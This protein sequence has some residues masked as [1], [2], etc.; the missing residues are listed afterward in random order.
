MI[1]A[2]A[3]MSAF[4]TNQQ[5]LDEHYAEILARLNKDFGVIEKPS[6]LQGWHLAECRF[7]K[8]GVYRIFLTRHSSFLLNDVAEAKRGFVRQDVLRVARE[9]GFIVAPNGFTMPRQ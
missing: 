3:R 2:K 4:A 6:D 9:L 5:E 7:Y 8:P 1:Q